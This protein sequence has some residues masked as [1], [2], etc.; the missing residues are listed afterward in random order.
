MGKEEISV[1]EKL[2]I[3]LNEKNWFTDGLRF[4]EEKSGVPRLYLIGGCVGFLALYL[5]VGYACSF[6]V[7][8]L[9]F[10]YPAYASVK[11]V[12]SKS[13]DDDTQWLTYWVVYAS[14]SIGEYFSDM[15]LSWFPMYFLFKCAFLCWCMAPFSWNGAEFIYSRFIQP[16]IAEHEKSVD[17]YI[18]KVKSKAE[19]LYNQAETKAK[20][21]AVDAITANV[22]SNDGEKND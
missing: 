11:A 20:E 4:V 15:F 7:S 18:N 16:F 19:E 8:L 3:F 6:V 14:F 2:E 10:L 22:K 1:K 21:V 17:V 13:K 5:I 9:G 12:E